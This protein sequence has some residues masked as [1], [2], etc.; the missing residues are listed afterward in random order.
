MRSTKTGNGGT[1]GQALA[2][3]EPQLPEKA[4]ELMQPPQWLTSLREAISGSI[5]PADLKEV[6]GAQV[7]KAREGDV[8]AAKFVMD[9]A[10]KL[11]A[12]QAKLQPQVTIVQNN[13]Y[14]TPADE[15]PNVPIQ[16]GDDASGKDL[17]Q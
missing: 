8:K 11:M 12:S 4:A 13:Y 15:R 14:D 16:P 7:A 2:R 6:I 10:H 5:A 3:R 1:N 9:Q 17:R